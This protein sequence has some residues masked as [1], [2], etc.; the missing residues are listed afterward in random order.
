M[1]AAPAFFICSISSYS[2][3]TYRH[4][5]PEKSGLETPKGGNFTIAGQKIG[6]FLEKKTQVI[7]IPYIKG[8]M[9][10]ESPVPQLLYGKKGD[11]FYR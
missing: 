6:F 11:C 2:S 7:I 4:Y 10:C 5:G 3:F 1:P 8:N 9:E